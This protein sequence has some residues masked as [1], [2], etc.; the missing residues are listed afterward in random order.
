MRA[1]TRT[2][3]G[4]VIAANGTLLGVLSIG[5]MIAVSAGCD[6][7]PET[8]R[9]RFNN[10]ANFRGFPHMPGNDVLLSYPNSRGLAMDGGSLF[11]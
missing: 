11:S 7:A 10:I 5:D 3:G 9:D 1:H 2:S 4:E 8:C 6:K